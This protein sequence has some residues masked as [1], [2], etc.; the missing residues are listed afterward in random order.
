M[1]RLYAVT[2]K[3]P[4]KNGNSHHPFVLMLSSN[5]IDFT[6]YFKSIYLASIENLWKYCLGC[7]TFEM[8]KL[9]QII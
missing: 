4:L 3:I 6:K 2:K 5:R 8:S 9:Q 1:F 7:D